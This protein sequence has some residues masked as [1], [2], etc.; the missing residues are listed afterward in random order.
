MGVK[1]TANL[2]MIPAAYA[3]DK[4][5][6]VLPSDGDGDFTF[7]RSGSGTRINK[8][9]YIET[10]AENVPRLNYR[11]DADGNPTGCAELLLEESRTNNQN[12]SEQFD[13]ST[14]FKHNSVSVTANAITAPNGTLTA[15]K[16]ISDGSQDLVMRSFGKGTIGSA[17]TFSVWAKKVILIN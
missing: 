11:L 6:S 2:A 5:Y 10:M 7:T 8:G 3:E 12:Y 13:N 16:I 17:N 15:D 4:V 9:G 1:D 14:Y